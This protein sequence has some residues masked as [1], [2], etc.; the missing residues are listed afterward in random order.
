MI[1]KHE[2][3]FGHLFGGPSM[4][5]KTNATPV[6]ITSYSQPHVLQQR[7]KEERLA[8]GDRVKADLGPVRL[9]SHFGKM[10]MYFCPMQVINVKERVDKGDGAKLPAEAILDGF[11]TILPSNIKPG[12]Y[13]LKNATLFSNGTLQVIA[14]KNTRF[15]ELSE[16]VQSHEDYIRSMRNTEPITF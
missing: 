9:E 1:R 12:L 3:L 11:E 5:E 15:E 10:I 7:M 2:P 14:D 8:H 13:T 16:H 4:Q 6:I